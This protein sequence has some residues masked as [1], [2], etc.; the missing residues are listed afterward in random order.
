MPLAK[1][2]GKLQQATLAI[3]QKGLGDPE[4]AAAVATDYLKMF[5]LVAVG[6]MWAMMAEKA[7]AK[8]NDDANGEARYYANKVKTARFYMY[9]LLPE[10]ASLFLRIMTGKAAIAQFDEDDF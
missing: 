3:A 10:S 4:E 6:Y 5:G 1:A 2:L 9:K 8:V 7:L